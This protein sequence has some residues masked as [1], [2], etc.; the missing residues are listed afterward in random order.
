MRTKGLRLTATLHEAATDSAV[1][2]R[3]AAVWA[4][5]RAAALRWA[6]DA[7]AAAPIVVVLLVLANRDGGHGLAATL[8]LGL[9]SVV[10]LPAVLGQL[11]WW[12]RTATVL[13]TTWLA[14]LVVGTTFA[15]Y[16]A[17][18]V[19]PLLQYAIA[20]VLV[21][22][23]S[24][25]WTRS[26]AP[27]G[28]VL[29][30]VVAF[31]I[32]QERAWSVWW[33]KA[34]FGGGRWA[35]LSWHNQSAALTGMFGVWF[36]GASL[37]STRLVR[38]GLAVL[39]ATGFAGTWLS[40][41][42]GGVAVTVGAAAIA[43]VLGWRSSRARGEASWRPALVVVTVGALT[44]LVVA[45]LLGMRPDDARQPIADR[46][47]SAVRTG[48][49]RVE[50]SE[51]ALGMWADR[52][53]TG[54]G[55]GSYA[56]LARQWNDSSGNLTSSAHN[57]YAEVA[58]ELGL[59]GLVALAGA[60]VGAAVLGWRVLRT[61]P[62]AKGPDDLRAPMVVGAVAG[63]ALFLVH[64]GLDFDWYYPVLSGMAAIA[65]GMLL[66][67]RAVVSGR[68]GLAPAT[69][70][71]MAAVLVV[72]VGLGLVE[73]RAREPLP[74]DNDVWVARAEV[75][76]ADGN[77]GRALTATHRTLRWNPASYG[78]LAVTDRAYFALT[79][80][81][82]ALVAATRSRPSWFTGQAHAA[83]ALAQAG[84]PEPAAALLT[85]LHADLDNHAAWGVT[86]TRLLAVEADVAVAAAD[87]CEAARAV[88]TQAMA[89]AGT[90][91]PVRA[92]PAVAPE[93]LAER[94]AMEGCRPAA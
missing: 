47:L 49:A 16:R 37:A 51:A 76:L 94:L 81:V 88:V 92:L 38:G 5:R 63:A 41:S 67:R 50:H 23:A 44:A 93:V 53:L 31:G 66:P 2:A 13:L 26:W 80:D 36:L 64:S 43:V 27:A 85:D 65:I 34:E 22:S 12:P 91:D 30:L 10:A 33:A 58:G 73:Q 7:A 70:V 82:D 42:R 55:P 46:D 57:E 72:T 74:W 68:Q 79:D 61:P 21:L 6:G 86:G 18:M 19:L 45:G 84:H 20:P 78:A 8:T 60:L 11:R 15:T 25:L 28:L 54:Q 32:H 48:L 3:P 62:T 14:A 83:L 77:V 90:D 69:A 29:L 39:A 24:R 1:E 40:S 4:D 56:T 71:A 52:P 35:P 9:S 17:D 59:L 75:A 87:S 89:A